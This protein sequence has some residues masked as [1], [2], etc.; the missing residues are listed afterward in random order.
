MAPGPLAADQS[1][2][3]TN[4]ESC[5]VVGLKGVKRKEREE[6]EVRKRKSP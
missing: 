3:T 5:G 4:G 2:L 1:R 6:E